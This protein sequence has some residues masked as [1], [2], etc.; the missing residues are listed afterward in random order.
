MGNG[1]GNDGSGVV[2]VNKVVVD[3][4]V[5]VELKSS[6]LDFLSGERFKEEVDRLPGLQLLIKL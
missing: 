5:V 6:L 4:V 1:G 3:G 2:V